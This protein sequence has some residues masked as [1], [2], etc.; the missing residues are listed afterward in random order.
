MDL[1]VRFNFTEL[2][3]KKREEMVNGCKIA[4]QTKTEHMVKNK[5]KSLISHKSKK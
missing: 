4:E 5:N 2:Y 1:R 3:K